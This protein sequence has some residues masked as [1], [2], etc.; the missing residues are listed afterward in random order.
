MR[1]KATINYPLP[2]RIRRGYQHSRRK[3]KIGFDL[4]GVVETKAPAFRALMQA[5][6]YQGWEVHI[7]TGA[8]WK[9]CQPTLKRL[10]IPFTHFFSITDHHVAIGTEV[11][12]SDPD[13]P[14]IDEHLWDKTKAIYCKVHAITMHFDDSDIYGLF[15][16][17]PYIRYFSKDSERV[18][19]MHIAGCEPKKKPKKK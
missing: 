2:G 4:H 10:R 7:I 5:L 1:C 19:K 3:N 15:F 12:W 14:H 17:T 8:A 6:I 13:N 9:H 11:E 16:Q 18:Q